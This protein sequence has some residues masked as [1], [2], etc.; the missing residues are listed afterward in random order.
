MVGTIRTQRFADG[1]VQAFA[2]H[3]RG[4]VSDSDEKLLEQER[5]VPGAEGEIHH[6]RVQVKPKEIVDVEDT[7]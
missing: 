2:V 1:T 6:D 7:E 3:S 5:L 4:V